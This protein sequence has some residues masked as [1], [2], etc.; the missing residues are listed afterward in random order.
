MATLNGVNFTTYGLSLSQAPSS[1]ISIEHCWDL[2]ERVGD[3][4]YSWA[5]NDAVTPFVDAE[6]LIYAGRDLTLHASIFGTNAEIRGHLSDLYT[7]VRAFT[8]PV[9]LASQYGSFSVLVKSIVPE[10]MHGAAK[11]VITFREPVVTL[12]GG[13]LPAA[14]VSLNTFDGIPFSSFGF[15]FSGAKELDSLPEAKEQFFTSYATEGYQLTKRE[16]NN[17]ELNGFIIATSL[18]DFNSKIL[19]LYKLF[20]KA[21]TIS[22]V[23]N[24][25][26][27][28]CFA[29][30]GFQ[31]SDVILYSS[32][33]VARFTIK[34]IIV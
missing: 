21:G 27:L 28:T 11:V 18:A 9:T 8:T 23:L 31:V 29:I 2:P 25:T 15:Y 32:G 34:M 30:E 14:A 16:A 6:D 13:T 22:V 33:M 3:T 5:E 1:N 10:M 24:G 26:T 7:A 19:A 20:T 17:F 4:Y 12:T